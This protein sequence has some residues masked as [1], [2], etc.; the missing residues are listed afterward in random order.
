MSLLRVGDVVCIPYHF[1]LV[2]SSN[3]AQ[4]CESVSDNLCKKCT[5]ETSE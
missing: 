5:N 1:N 2:E 4:L 3:V